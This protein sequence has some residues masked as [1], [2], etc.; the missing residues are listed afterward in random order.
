M[1]QQPPDREPVT[2]EEHKQA[3][4]ELQ[5]WEPGQGPDRRT[6]FYGRRQ[7]DK[8]KE[9]DRRW[10]IVAIITLGIGVA[11]SQFIINS[12]NHDIRT[13]QAN[14]AN[15]VVATNIWGCAIVTAPTPASRLNYLNR[16]GSI[17]PGELPPICRK[18]ASSSANQAA[19]ALSGR[20]IIAG[21]VK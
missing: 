8:Q 3:E 5:T 4:I 16:Y 12:Q 13:N 17:L 6:R 9:I 11:A 18:V 19:R 1:E 20:N 14:I 21:E 10:L 2:E 7:S 15:I